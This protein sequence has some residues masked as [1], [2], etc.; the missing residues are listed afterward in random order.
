MSEKR[1]YQD[2]MLNSKK[3][4]VICNWERGTGKTYSIL[5]KAM[6]CDKKCAYF[7]Y[8]EGMT[9]K[10]HVNNI[11][12]EEEKIQIKPFY[13]FENTSQ[14]TILKRFKDG[15]RGIKLEMYYFDPNNVDKL[16]GLKD[17]RYA[18]FDE[19]FPSESILRALRI[20]GVEQI[21]IMMTNDNVEYINNRNSTKIENF[22]DN[23]IEELMIEYSDVSKTEKTTLT[24][25]KILQ[26]I[27]I[28]QEMKK[29]TN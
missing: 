8:N 10:N 5:N 4:I 21:F 12:K 13:E 23:Q 28:L 25:E 6:Y 7:S 19:C 14:R 26:Q 29:V 2:K 17:F 9:I 18:F 22:Y 3:E 20:I 16:R 15:I 11:V 1:V 24:R 27:H